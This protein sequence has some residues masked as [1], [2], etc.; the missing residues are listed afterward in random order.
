MY[1][2]S[3]KGGVLKIYDN[4]T[5]E[6]SYSDC[7]YW[8]KGKNS[9]TI[10][11]QSFSLKN[12]VNISKKTITVTTPFVRTN[13]TTF[14]PLKFISFRLFNITFGKNKQLAKFIKKI[15]VK[16][17][18]SQ[19]K[20][21]DNFLTRKITFSDDQVKVEDFISLKNKQIENNL[22]SDAKFSTIHMGSSRYF[23]MDEIYLKKLN[24]KNQKEFYLES[25]L[26]LIFYIL[27]DSIPQTFALSYHY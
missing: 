11:S 24:S 15:I 23:S 26:I 2:S 13:Q 17:L 8:I 19:R 22:I 16:T 25:I 14:T 21:T 12:K 5:N 10:S 6:I 27:L 4:Q 3:S 9:I 1:F 18:V 7:G 20:V